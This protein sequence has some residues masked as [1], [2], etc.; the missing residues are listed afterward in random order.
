MKED[1]LED[2]VR[3]VESLALGVQR[4]IFYIRQQLGMANCFEPSPVLRLILDQLGY[5][6]YYRSEGY[7]LEKIKKVR[8]VKPRGAYQI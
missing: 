6:L 1:E 5:V 8:I 2:R 7:Y 4:E 3:K